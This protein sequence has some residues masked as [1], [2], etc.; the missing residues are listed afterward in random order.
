MGRFKKILEDLQNNDPE[1]IS[2]INDISESIDESDSSDFDDK[3]FSGTEFTVRE[4]LVHGYMVTYQYKKVLA[5]VKGKTNNNATK[6][7]MQM[8]IISIIKPLNQE[9]VNDA[10]TTRIIHK[11]L[12]DIIESS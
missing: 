7:F 11:K 5:A 6:E 4:E 12:I 8:R 3:V 10:D 2:L 9:I 1:T